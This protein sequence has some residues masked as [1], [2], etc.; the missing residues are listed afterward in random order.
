M[1][2][3]LLFLIDNNPN[4][5]KIINDNLKGIEG[6]YKVIKQDA[7]SFLKTTNEQFDIVLL[8]P[9]YQTDLGIL[10]IDFIV[11]NN[12]LKN[13]GIIIFETSEDKD[14]KFDYSNLQISKKKYGTVAVYK[15]VKI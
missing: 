11:K 15:L 12:L 9:P 4:A 7:L 8:D 1:L 3:I 13:N 5:I 6:D 14:F 10:S 2:R